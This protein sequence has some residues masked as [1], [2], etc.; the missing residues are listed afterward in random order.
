MTEHKCGAT[1]ADYLARAAKNATK[2]FQIRICLLRLGAIMK[3]AQVRK[4]EN[5]S[6]NG[7]LAAASEPPKE[8]NQRR[9]YHRH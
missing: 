5:A 2:N 7:N 8:E 9:Q 6:L 4:P 1:K 3:I